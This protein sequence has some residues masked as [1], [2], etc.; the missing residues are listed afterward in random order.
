MENV[1]DRDPNLVEDTRSYD[2]SAPYSRVAM[3]GH[4]LTRNQTCMNSIN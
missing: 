1:R 4:S 2:S 3:Y